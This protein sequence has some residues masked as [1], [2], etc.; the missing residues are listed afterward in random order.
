[1]HG[2][3]DKNTAASAAISIK[4]CSLTGVLSQEIWT[5]RHSR[6]RPSLAKNTWAN[7]VSFMCSSLSLPSRH[8]ATIP[9]WNTSPN[10]EFTVESRRRLLSGSTPTLLVPTTWRPIYMYLAI[11]HFQWPGVLCRRLPELLNRT[12]AFRRQISQSAR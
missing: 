4:R 11:E 1:V 10:M 6:P 2:W 9:G 5:R 3:S 12:I 7:P 8:H